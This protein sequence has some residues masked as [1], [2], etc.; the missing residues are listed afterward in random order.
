MA[1]SRKLADV[2]VS[3]R[4]TLAG[5]PQRHL[6]VRFE[7][8]R[9]S[10]PD[11]VCWFELKGFGEQRLHRAFGV[12]TLQALTLAIEGARVQLEH[13]KLRLTGTFVDERGGLPR[14]VLAPF[15]RQNNDEIHLALDR[16]TA[17]V[18]RRLIR[19]GKQRSKGAS[20]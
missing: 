12:D 14:I 10:G 8:P 2:I 11:W 15:G 18:A 17:R 19:E 9:R 4:L 5:R 20:A 1:G 3:R 13:R 16:A 7:R 6:T